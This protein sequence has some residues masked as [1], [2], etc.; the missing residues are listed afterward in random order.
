MSVDERILLVKHR[1]SFESEFTAEPGTRIFEWADGPLDERGSL[2]NGGERIEI[3]MPGDVDTDGVRQYIRVDRVNYDDKNGWPT[4]AD[5]NGS[6][7]TR[8]DGKS[9]G[10]DVINWHGA[11]PTPGGINEVVE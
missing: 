3:S 10:N 9:Y 11:G 5:G 6:S 7:L 2:S 8:V 1:D 4:E